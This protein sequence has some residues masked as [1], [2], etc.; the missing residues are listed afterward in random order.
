MQHTFNQPIY[1]T[2]KDGEMRIV[3]EAEMM[4]ELVGAPENFA[5]VALYAFEL[6]PGCPRYEI[7]RDDPEYELCVLY[8]RLNPQERER[9]AEEWPADERVRESVVNE[10]STHWGSP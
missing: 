5:V 7:K 8:L 3:A 2:G 10:H 1:F 6:A 9:I 4:A